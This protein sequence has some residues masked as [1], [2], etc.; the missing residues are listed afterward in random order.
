MINGSAEN[1]VFIA[2]GSSI[3]ATV[4]MVVVA[5]SVVLCLKYRIWI[6]KQL[7]R[8]RWVNTE[9]QY[10]RPYYDESFG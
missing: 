3:A 9:P 8:R 4:V 7:L 1:Q 5:L 6:L 10:N 2:I